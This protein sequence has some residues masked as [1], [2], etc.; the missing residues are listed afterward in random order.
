MARRRNILEPAV[1]KPLL[2]LHAALDLTSFW[3][4]IQ[5]VINVALPGSFLG[6]TLQHNPV[7]P[8]IAKWSHPIPDG[9]FNSTLL[10]NYLRS[11]PRRRF[12]RSN[13]IFPNMEKLEKSEFYQ[14]YMEPQKRRHAIGMFFWRGQRLI[15]VIVIMRTARQGELNPRQTKLLQQLYPQFQTALHRLGSLE[16][17]HSTRIA[18]GEFLRR[19]PLPTILLRWNLTLVYQNRA[20]REFCALWEKGPKIARVL[21]ADDPVPFEILEG[22]RGLKQQWQEFPRSSLATARPGGEMVRHPN[23]PNLRATISLQQIRSAGV[24]RPRFLVE[25]EDFYSARS[26][27]Q[28]PHMIRLTRREQD[29][30]R[31]VCDGG[32]NQEIADDASLSLSMVKK[33][34]HSV[35]RKLEI[36]SRSQL[37]ALM[38]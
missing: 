36:T 18:L 21:K 37:M 13:D 14:K 2:R 23:Q 29:V 27:E 8:M 22:C 28:L 20:A 4:A 24:A 38:R 3:K 35:F 17:E 25:C 1:Q 33:H 16:R 30:T 12:V 9:N 19:L 10:Q 34:L 11:H 32:S 31:L 6:L 7:M 5:G 15:G 26:R